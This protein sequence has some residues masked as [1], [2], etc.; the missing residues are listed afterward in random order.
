M[1]SKKCPQCGSLTWELAE[2]CD[3]GFQ[4]PRIQK[5]EISMPA[6]QARK[7]NPEI[8]TARNWY[9]WLWI[10]PLI[11][12]PTLSLLLFFA[13]LVDRSGSNFWIVFLLP[14]LGS[15]LWHLILLYPAIKGKTNFIRWH[16]RQ[17][18]LLAGARTALALV[19]ALT[20]N[21]MGSGV[22]LLLGF[23]LFLLWSAGNL[24]GQGQAR[25]GDCAL[26]RWRG[27]GAGLPRP[28]GWEV[29]S[30]ESSTP[31]PGLEEIDRLVG[32][33]RFNTDAEQRRAAL[34]ELERL[35]LVEAL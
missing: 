4:F 28:L 31:S 11:T 7:S 8:Q 1:A 32:V 25:R 35:G 29:A 33:I 21:W 23:L 10:S 26:M 3:C 19:A 22:P 5:K 30:P 24:W 15:A 9:I 34:A 6:A 18:L 14:V 16:G 17:A 27:H 20:S 12:L 2:R 13:Y